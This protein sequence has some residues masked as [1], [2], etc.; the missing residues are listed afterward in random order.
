MSNKNERSPAGTG[1]A[2][3]LKPLTHY[4]MNNLVN[5]VAHLE[6]LIKHDSAHKIR[7]EKYCEFETGRTWRSAAE[8]ITIVF[9]GTFANVTPVTDEEVA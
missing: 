9:A 2:Q 4:R 3:K 6:H 5:I 8:I 1:C 7:R